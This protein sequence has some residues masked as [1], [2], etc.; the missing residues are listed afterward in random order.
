M[1]RLDPTSLIASQILLSILYVWIFYFIHRA[2]PYLRGARILAGAFFLAT[3]ARLG[4]VLA[5]LLGH[6]FFVKI[7]NALGLVEHVLLYLAILRYFESSRPL[8]LR[9]IW[10]LAIPISV[11]VLAYPGEISRAWLLHWIYVALI[12]LIRG[13]CARELFRHAAG[14]PAVRVFAIFMTFFSFYVIFRDVVPLMQGIVFW[15]LTPFGIADLLINMTCSDLLEFFFL[16]LM[17][18]SIM[19]IMEHQSLIDPLT[20]KLNRRGIEANLAA[21]LVRSARNGHIFSVALIDLDYFKS[22]NDTLG[23]AAGDAALCHVANTIAALVRQYDSVGR[24][25]GDEMLL[26]MPST[27]GADAMLIAERICQSVKQ[28]DFFQ[29][30][31]LST[32]IGVAQCEVLD[33]AASILARADTALYQAKSAGRGCARLQTVGSPNHESNTGSILQ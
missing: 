31:L 25:G 13:F 27:N 11:A 19:Q 28:S 4:Y 15:S 18:S 3:L 2:F 32:S 5:A 23:H 1:A 10:F 24:L 6:D 16:F 20:G 14:R 30:T 33:S 22:V 21:E 29:G 12:V 8:T 7:G 26:I 17:G 9:I